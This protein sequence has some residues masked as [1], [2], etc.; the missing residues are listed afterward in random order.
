MAVLASEYDGASL[1]SVVV[2]QKDG[3]IH[4]SDPV[5]NDHAANK[6]YVD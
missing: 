6:A 1:R 3:H 4:T 2:R 5:D